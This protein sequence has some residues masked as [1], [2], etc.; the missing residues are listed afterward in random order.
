MNEDELKGE[1]RLYA[2]EWMIC[3]MASVLL[4]ASG[5]P[6]GI[7]AKTRE[8]ALA[9]ARQKTFANVNPAVSDLLSAELESAVDRLLTMTQTLAGTDRG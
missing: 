2:L 8:Q 7:L 3:Q 9:G 4:R 6:A 5:D 1:V